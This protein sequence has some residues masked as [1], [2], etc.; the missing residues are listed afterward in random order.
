MVKWKGDFGVTGNATNQSTGAR[1]ATLPIR[2]P[3]SSARLSIC[4]PHQFA[5]QPATPLQLISLAS[6]YLAIPSDY[7]SAL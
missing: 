7:E 3:D 6:L 2:A 4:L 5:M 1:G